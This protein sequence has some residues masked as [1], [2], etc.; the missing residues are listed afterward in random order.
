MGNPKNQKDG[1]DQGR[2]RKNTKPSPNSEQQAKRS[3]ASDQL[4]YS[5]SCPMPD[6]SGLSQYMPPM[7]GP[8]SQPMPPMQHYMQ[9]GMGN[10]GTLQEILKKLNGMETKLNKLDS[11]DGKLSIIDRRVTELDQTVKSLNEKVQSL[12]ESRQF[13]SA[14]IE[15]IKLKQAEIGGMKTDISSLKQQGEMAARNVLDLQT[16]SMRD[17]LMFFNIQEPELRPKEV[18]NCV[19]TVINFCA[20]KLEILDATAIKLDRA[21]R[22][23]P[24]RRGKNRPIVAKFNHYQ[25][26]EKVRSAWPKLKETDYGISEQ[27]PKEIQDR[28]KILLQIKKE[29]TAKGRQCSMSVDKLFVDGRLHKDPRITWE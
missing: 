3:M 17:N 16:R 8:Y 4:Q 21:H 23:G 6:L 26:R 10:N 24:K 1:H 29:E 5:Q 22:V 9:Q 11:I 28:R 7:P 13:D 12:E 20:E 25:D 18:E 14:T 27:F 2:K 19:E 15:E